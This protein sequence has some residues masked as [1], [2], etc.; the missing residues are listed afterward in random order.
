MKKF[1]IITMLLLSTLF[2][3]AQK[4]IDSKIERVTVFLNGAQVIRT[5]ATSLPTGKS[6]LIF[7]GLTPNLEAQSVIVKGEGDFTILSVKHQFNFLEIQKRKDTIVQLEQMREELYTKSEQMTIALNVLKQEE[8]MLNRNRVQILGIGNT[9]FKTEDLKNLHEYQRTQM[10]Q[11]L[12]KTNELNKNLTQIRLEVNKINA[13]LTELNAKKSI[14]TAEVVVTVFVKPTPSVSAKFTL[15]YLVPNANWYPLYDLRVRDVTSPMQAQMKAKVR[16]NSG[17]DWNEVKITLSTGEPKRTGIKPEL[18]VWRIGS[19]GSTSFFG[20]NLNQLNDFQAQRQQNLSSNK[21]RGILKDAAS[22]EPL[23]G[24]VISVKGSHKGTV[25]DIEGNFELDLNNNEHVLV[26]TYVGYHNQEIAVNGSFIA[27]QLTPNATTLSEVIVAGRGGVHSVQGAVA[28]TPISSR[29]AKSEAKPTAPPPSTSVEVRENEKATT[30][31]FD[32]EL[33]YTLPSDAKEYLVEVKEVNLPANYQYAC[34]PK[35]DN[36][37]FL[38]AEI[39]DWTQYSL[40]EGEANLYFEGTFLGKTLLK[41]NSTDDT[42]RISLGRD[43]NVVVKREKQREFSKNALFSSKRTDTRTFEISVKNKKSTPLSI[44]LEDQIPISTDKQ[45]EVEF[46][47]SGAELN[48]DTGRLTWKLKLQPS[49][50]KKIRFSYSV[51]HPADWRY[52]LE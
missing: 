7:R 19:Y 25:T 24:A 34:A 39:V 45:V 11:I 47:A 14:A 48:K 52:N 22:G 15:E 51:R 50:D 38:T 21:V 32:I 35:L 9:T 28:G 5:A 8:D 41:T 44:V 6:D 26:A 23:M 3:L 16:Q 30:A 10:T 27:A 12:T 37:A 13:Q 1:S 29:K 46:D 42:L 33:P 36:D 4:K 20:R 40:L 49:E 17:E 43:K 2:A 18:G 31:S